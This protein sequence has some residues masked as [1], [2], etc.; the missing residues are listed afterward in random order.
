MPRQT[1]RQKDIYLAGIAGLSALA[2]QDWNAPLQDSVFSEPAFPSPLRINVTTIPG[3][4]KPVAEGV[5]TVWETLFHYSD[6]PELGFVET[7]FSTYDE[8]DIRILKGGWFSSNRPAPPRAPWLPGAVNLSSVESKISSSRGDV[9]NVSLIIPEQPSPDPPL[10]PSNASTSRKT[11]NMTVPDTT[12]N[13]ELI[14]SFDFDETAPRLTPKSVYLALANMI[15]RIA[16]RGNTNR[17]VTEKATDPDEIAEAQLVR[18]ATDSRGR[19]IVVYRQAK[20]LPRAL[21]IV[22][23]HDTLFVT[24]HVDVFNEGGDM[25]LATLSLGKGPRWQPQNVADIDDGVDVA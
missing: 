25:L 14:L 10:M 5:W 24:G 16:P 6:H 15:E 9:S 4:V 20:G 22:M 7:V 11:F 1:F 3:L 17:V 18:H 12:T 13:G 21:A 2:E 8:N 23:T 19:G